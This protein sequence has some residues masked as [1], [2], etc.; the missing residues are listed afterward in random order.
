M[1]RVQYHSLEERQ[2]ILD[3]RPDLFLIREENLFDGDFL[4]FDSVVPQQVGTVELR[5]LE[6]QT[7]NNLLKAQNQAISERA[8]FHEDLITD[9]AMMIYQ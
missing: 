7:E 4:V 3:G 9:M 8:D 5:L 2:K 1:E 6:L